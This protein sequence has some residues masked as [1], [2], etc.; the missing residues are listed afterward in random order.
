MPFSPSHLR[1]L[2][3]QAGLTRTALAFHCDKSEQTVWLWE[4]GDVTQPANVVERIAQ[5]LD[6]KVEDLFAPANDNDPASGRAEVGK[7]VPLRTETH[8]E[9]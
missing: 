3:E 7:C 6:C 2:R 8:G 4:R 9:A 1:A 5:V